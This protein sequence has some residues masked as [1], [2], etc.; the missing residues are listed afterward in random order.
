[1][2]IHTVR[3]RPLSFRLVV[4]RSLP[5]ALACLEKDRAHQRI[6]R[7]DK[8][9]DQQSA[10][11]CSFS[12]EAMTE[13]G[14]EQRSFLTLSAPLRGLL[15]PLLFPFIPTLM[16]RSRRL[17]QPDSRPA[18]P[19]LWR[20]ASPR[21]PGCIVRQRRGPGSRAGR[22]PSQS[23]SALR[24]QDPLLGPALP[25]SLAGNNLQCTAHR[26]LFGTWTCRAPPPRHHHPPS[27]RR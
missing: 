19:H 2:A 8:R 3:R 5:S 15:P 13:G 23:P 10:T 20:Q 26:T 6:T 1:M 22:L 16:S 4:A 14:E 9:K 25:L 11:S 24:P 27:R 7:E 21:S 18:S 17:L 12:A